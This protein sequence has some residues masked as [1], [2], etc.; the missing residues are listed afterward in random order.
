MK[1]LAKADL[2]FE[3]KVVPLQDAIAYFQSKG[4]DEKVQL[5]KF[6]SKDLGLLY[7]LRDRCD[8]H[9]G[10]MVPS[11]GYL[12]WFALTP[13]GGRFRPALP[14]PPRAQRT[15]PAAAIPRSCSPPSANTTT[16]SCGWASK[17]SAR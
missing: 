14:A 16:G 6:R 2:P 3:R 15:A 1:E 8:Y 11:T 4:Q 9:H 13:M 5:L 12:R 10:F 17:T 7:K